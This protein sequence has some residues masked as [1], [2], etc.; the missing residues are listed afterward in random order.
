MKMLP[1]I[2][3][4]QL[5]FKGLVLAPDESIVGGIEVPILLSG[6]VSA[7]DRILILT[8]K[9]MH[10]VPLPR[11]KISFDAMNANT[12]ESWPLTSLGGASKISEGLIIMAVDGR[13]IDVIVRDI[14]PVIALLNTALSLY[15]GKKLV[16]VEKNTWIV[17]PIILGEDTKHQLLAKVD[18]MKKELL[19][20]YTQPE[21]A[22]QLNALQTRTNMFNVL[23]AIGLIIF[24]IIFVVTTCAK[25]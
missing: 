14:T 13:N 19:D 21:V 25:K 8:D 20:K 9:N 16:A 6:Q 2:E 5:P 4:V 24:V 10:C 11:F 12:I 3:L 17:Q 1:Q 22:L 23:V 18:T 15:H 7:G